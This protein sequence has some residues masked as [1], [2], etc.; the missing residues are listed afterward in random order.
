MNSQDLISRNEEQH[1]QY[2][3]SPSLDAVFQYV[4]PD[5]R[6][7]I[8]LSI[9]SAVYGLEVHKSRELVNHQVGKYHSQHIF[10]AHLW[11]PA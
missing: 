6:Y 3:P 11:W 1:C 8:S 10:A 9:S 4:T 5:C 2:T 7:F